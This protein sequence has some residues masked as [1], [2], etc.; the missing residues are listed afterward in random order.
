MSADSRYSTGGSVS[1]ATSSTPRAT[2]NPARGPLAPM[3][4]S[5]RV[6]RMGSRMRMT[7]PKV[8]SANGSG[9]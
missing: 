5:W 7:A 9:M 2:T 1:T 6:R 4:K 8:P 3:S